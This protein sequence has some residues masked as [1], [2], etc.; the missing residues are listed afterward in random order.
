VLLPCS[1]YAV[2]TI[3]GVFFRGDPQDSEF[4]IASTALALLLIGIHNAWDSV[5]HIV[6]TAPAGDGEKK[7]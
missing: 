1:V 2:L 7:Q 5:T 4:V 3:A 6:I